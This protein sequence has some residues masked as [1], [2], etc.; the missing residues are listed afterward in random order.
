MRRVIQ[1]DIERQ[2]RKADAKNER[3]RRVERSMERVSKFKPMISKELTKGRRQQLVTILS[4]TRKGIELNEVETK[5]RKTFHDYAK[6]T[7]GLWNNV[8][9]E[10]DRLVAGKAYKGAD[11]PPPTG[12]KLTENQKMR[13]I[14]IIAISRRRDLNPQ[15]QADRGKFLAEARAMGIERQIYEQV[16]GFVEEKVAKDEEK[17]MAAQVA[18]REDQWRV[19]LRACIAD[20][21]KV[22]ATDPAFSSSDQ[23]KAEHLRGLLEPRAWTEM[24]VKSQVHEVQILLI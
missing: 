10:V 3:D 19:V 24:A 5:N 14:H 12:M 23:E 7:P 9:D 1:K 8:L 21:L 13:L 22:M 2:Q 17:K 18:R 6:M 15:E 16:D 11:T 4:K 20:F